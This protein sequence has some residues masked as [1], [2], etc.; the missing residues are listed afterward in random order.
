M[1]SH[2][3]TPVFTALPLLQRLA[4]RWLASRPLQGLLIGLIF[5]L[6]G[7]QI[8]PTRPTPAPSATETSWNEHLV[9]L[10]KLQDWR[11]RGKIGYVGAKDSG[12]AY[13]DW[14]QSRDSFHITLTGPLGQGATIIEGN[15]QGA[16]LH[17]N[18]GETFVAESP[19]QLLL[20]HTGIELPVSQLYLWI[21]G[22][23]SASNQERLTVS[24]EHTLLR[25]QQNQW[26][27]TYSNYQHQLG[28]LL[29]TRIRLQGPEMRLT[30]IAK[31]WTHAPNRNR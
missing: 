13:I 31:E 10:H 19:E 15:A 17:S 22:M 1:R 2:A 21:K 5:A 28:T 11:M 18:R 27:L 29:P 24:D 23:P 9:A 8:L 4:Q 16:R 6:S 26:T 3:L 12:S 20:E 25:L 14:V 7:C 30:L